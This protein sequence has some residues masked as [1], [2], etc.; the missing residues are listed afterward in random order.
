MPKVT[1]MIAQ[2]WDTDDFLDEYSPEDLDLDTLVDL[3]YNR[4]DEDMSYLVKYD[5][6]RS[7]ITHIVEEE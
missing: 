1:V 2:T 3:A 5:E 7:A 4:F 6:V